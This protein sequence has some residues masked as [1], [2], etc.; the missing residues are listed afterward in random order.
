M[1]SAV[2]RLLLVPLLAFCACASPSGLDGKSVGDNSGRDL[3]GFLGAT[4]MTIGLAK[5]DLSASTDDLGVTAPDLA[6]TPQDLATPHDDLAVKPADMTVASGCGSV[7]YAGTCSGN[8]VTY[9]SGNQVKTLTCSSPTQ[10][11]VV[12]GDANCR[13]VAGSP[14]GSVDYNGLCSGDTLV[15]CDA[16]KLVVED[17]TAA[18]TTSCTTSSGGVAYCK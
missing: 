2:Q 3:G 4:D 13:Y 7:T 18:P 12:A 1:R 10:C 17:C 9:C 8:V 6:K 11:T 15:Y 5:P 16:S 14:C